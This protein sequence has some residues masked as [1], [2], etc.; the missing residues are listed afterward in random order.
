VRAPDYVIRLT[1]GSHVLERD[2]REGSGA[3]IYRPGDDLPESVA[4]ELFPPKA[5]E[6]ER[7]PVRKT[8]KPR[9]ASTKES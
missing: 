2:F 8:T 1:D 6:P 3:M 9:R 5:E 7:K 4:A